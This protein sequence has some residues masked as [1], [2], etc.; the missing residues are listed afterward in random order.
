M[1]KNS[2]NQSFFLNEENVKNLV[3]KKFQWTAEGYNKNYKGVA[4]ITAVD[5]SAEHPLTVKTIEGDDLSFAY[6]E[7]FGLRAKG[8]GSYVVDEN[9]PK[10]FTY[11]DDYREVEIL[12]VEM[13]KFRDLMHGDNVY[14]VVADF[15]KKT[16]EVLTLTVSAIANTAVPDYA[17]D[18]SP[19]PH[20]FLRINTKEGKS[21][22]LNPRESESG[23][24]VYTAEEDAKAYAETLRNFF[25]AL[26]GK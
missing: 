21:F 25:S 12:E 16:V 17:K 22:V 4:V 26:A 7:G 15:D 2:E 20:P 6:V 5:M 11:S 10:C 13:K 14:E 9:E 19:A 3:G 8:D 18:D 24:N 23:V 1:T